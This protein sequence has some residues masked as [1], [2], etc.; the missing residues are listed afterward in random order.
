MK[1]KPHPTVALHNAQRAL[2]RLAAQMTNPDPTVSAEYTV[3][4]AKQLQA[5]AYTLFNLVRSRQ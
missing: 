2:D 1:R 5:A 3:E 4:C